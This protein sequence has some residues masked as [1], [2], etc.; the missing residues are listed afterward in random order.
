LEGADEVLGCGG[1]YGEV[2]A[3]GEEYRD[4]L[5]ALE[6]HQIKNMPLCSEFAGTRKTQHCMTPPL[7]GGEAGVRI[8][9][10][11]LHNSAH[12]QVELKT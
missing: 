12:L 10:A 8:P 5:K 3:S 6:R 9:S 2:P 11:P 1:L 4:V 7:H